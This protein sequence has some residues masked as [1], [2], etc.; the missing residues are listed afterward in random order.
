MQ[1][2]LRLY[3]PS[4]Q[5]DAKTS[6]PRFLSLLSKSIDFSYQDIFGSALKVGKGKSR[7]LLW[8]VATRSYALIVPLYNR[9]GGG[10]DYEEVL[11]DCEN[12]LAELEA[13]YP[14][15]KERCPLC[16]SQRG[17]KIFSVSGWGSKGNPTN[18]IAELLG[19]A[20]S[21]SGCTI[22]YAY[23]FNR[24]CGDCSHVWKS[25]RIEDE[26]VLNYAAER[27][28]A[29]EIETAADIS[30]A[31]KVGICPKCECSVVETNSR[32]SCVNRIDGTKTC[33]FSVSKVVL[34]QVISTDDVTELLRSGRTKLLKGFRSNKTKRKFSAFLAFDSD[35]KVGFE[36]NK[37]PG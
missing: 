9:L 23:S 18:Y 37:R 34:S 1:D 31:V 29:I 17:T 25:D 14:R 8:Q 13:K 12:H 35:G 5:E 28:S 27:L 21:R 22:S 19:Y 30:I 2:I 20:A 11:R 7:H 32:Y 26:T 24:I 4:E 10:R 36:F 33:D 3:S 15:P 16:K 6:W